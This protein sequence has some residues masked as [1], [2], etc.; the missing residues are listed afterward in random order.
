MKAEATYFVTNTDGTVVYFTDAQAANDYANESGA[1]APKVLKVTVNFDSNQGTAVDSQVVA[2]GNKVAK[3]ADPTKEGYT[4]TGWFTDED[5]TKAYD[6]DAVVDGAEPEFTLYA[7]WKAVPSP[8]VKP[9]TGNNSSAGGNTANNN[10]DN[11]AKKDTTKKTANGLPA[12]G[13]NAA[14][15]AAVGVAGAALIAAGAAASKRREKMN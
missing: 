14:A 12:T 2:T 5:C 8:A 9:S 13:D 10:R 6:F 11:A 1:Q 4:F 7:G 3:P 15:I